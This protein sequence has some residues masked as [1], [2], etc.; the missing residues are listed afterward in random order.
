MAGWLAAMGQSAGNAAAAGAGNSVG[1]F[2]GDF[3]D[4][5]TDKA[6]FGLWGKYQDSQ[7]N[8]ER[9]RQNILNED[10]AMINFKY[11]EQAA[12]AAMRRAEDMYNKYESYSA[13]RQQMEAAGLNPA[14]MYG[15]GGST[16]QSVGSGQQGGGAAGTAEPMNQ[17]SMMIAAAEQRS[18]SLEQ[19]MISAQ[20]ENIKA[21]TREKNTNADSTGGKDGTVGASQIAKNLADAGLS[22]AA[23]AN[24]EADT[25]LKKFQQKVNDL[26][27]AEQ[28]EE[29]K[30]AVILSRNAVDISHQ[31]LRGAKMDNDIKSANMQNVVTEQAYRTAQAVALY[32]KIEAET[33]AIAETIAQGW[34]AI[35]NASDANEV[36]RER[37]DMDRK[38]SN[39]LGGIQQRGQDIDQRERHYNT[40]R[41]S[42]AIVYG[43]IAG[44]L[45]GGL[46]SGAAKMIGGW[47][48]KIPTIGF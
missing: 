7:W 1:Q 18:V 17:A 10:A 35:A 30:N 46:G 20:I 24:E 33:D 48:S 47:Q 32:Y 2:A 27:E 23:T 8:K 43:N 12:D 11:G 38:I 39:Y 15:M 25:A 41:I 42:K 37:I 16:G 14:L 13:Q 6:T 34:A 26:T 22:K 5:M 29:L 28:V 9:N 36:Q 4:W 44:S 3:S 31:E 19:Q 21:D 40:D 45:A